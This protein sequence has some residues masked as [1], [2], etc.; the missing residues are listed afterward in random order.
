VCTLGAGERPRGGRATTRTGPAGTRAGPETSSPSPSGG[1]VASLPPL[2]ALASLP[3][4]LAVAS[5][6]TRLATAPLQMTRGCSDHIVPEYLS[7][8]VNQDQDHSDVRTFE[9]RESDH[10]MPPFS[11]SLRL[12]V[13]PSPCLSV[14]MSLRLPVSLS[15]AV[16]ESLSPC[17][18]VFLS[19]CFPVSPSAYLSVSLSLPL[20]LSAFC[21]NGS[22]I[23]S[24]RNL[25][26]LNMGHKIVS[27]DSQLDS[28]P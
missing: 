11:P 7:V 19:H 17:L 16:S 14:S 25:G 20:P 27:Y 8:L 21:W 22:S 23:W 9:N 10:R 12:P 4:L 3:P 18:S 5:L 24:T 28:Q 13:S 26:Q 6:A 1:A 15:E 2:L